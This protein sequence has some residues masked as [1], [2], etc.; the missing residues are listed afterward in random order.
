M[1]K[2]DKTNPMQDWQRVLFEENISLY[3][4]AMK[5]YGAERY[6]DNDLGNAVLFRLCEN[7][8][9]FNPSMGTISTFV[10][11]QVRYALSHAKREYA[12]YCKKQQKIIEAMRLN[13]EKEYCLTD[14]SHYRAGDLEDALAKLPLRL[15]AVVE[16]HYHKQ[17]SL[18]ECG[19]AMGRSKQRFAQLLK[20]AQQ[21]LA[22]SMFTGEVA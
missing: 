15:R 8:H 20:M 21:R 13:L 16:L 10:F 17:L 14:N 12:F 19:V 5:R 7:M 6:I 18:Q 11:M 9:K 4:S 1:T 22:K 2:K 3:Y